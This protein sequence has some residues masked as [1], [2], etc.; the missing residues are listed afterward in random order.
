MF[1]L[2]PV[3]VLGACVVF[4]FYHFKKAYYTPKDANFYIVESIPSIF[5]TL[6]IMC[7]AA[8]IAYGLYGFDTN[9]IQG[10]LPRLLG[11]LKSAFYAT[12]AGIIG[13]VAA[14]MI[15]SV[16]QNRI[17]RMPDRP[18]KVSDELSALSLISERLEKL[19][20]NVRWDLQK[21]ILITEEGNKIYNNQTIEMQRLIN[22]NTEKEGEYQRVNNEFNKRLFDNNTLLLENGLKMYELLNT[23][24]KLQESGILGVVEKI[25]D[26]NKILIKKFDEFSD[27]LRKSNTESLV[28]VMKA[29]TE[30]FNEQMKELLDTIVK[31]NFK[32]L[33]TSVK[34]L[35]TW[36]IENKEQVAELT[37]QV[38][39]ILEQISNATADL[40]QVSETLGEVVELSQELVDEDGKLNLLVQELD[41]VMI[42]DGK[43][44]EITRKV[45]RSVETMTR[46]T[47]AFE[48]TTQ[49]LNG[50]VRNQMNFNEKAEIIVH[51]LEEFRNLNGSVWD[52]YRKEMETSVNIISQTSTVLSED[53]ENIN[54]EFYSRLNDTLQ[55]LDGLIQRFMSDQSANRRN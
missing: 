24:K 44:T 5:P 3:I 27:L 28:E 19:E 30:Q 1:E 10:S 12:I 42:S 11:G 31:E 22:V 53:L 33:N 25:D 26:R 46:T 29:S 4:S 38:R 34:M 20:S 21:V 52:K 18:R 48:E 17:D 50:W 32:E 6:G 35:N 15:L 13:L 51:Q 14:Q 40:E 49:K 39:T 2:G 36:Q 55:S 43:F 41:K 37:S 7:T 45:D 8:G 47:D 9:D 54:E 16:I 23:H